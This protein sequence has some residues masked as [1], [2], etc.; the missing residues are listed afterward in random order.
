V[1][2]SNDGSNWGS[3]LATGNPTTQLVTISFPSQTARYIKVVQTG[4]VASNWWSIAELN[5]YNLRLSAPLG[6]SGARGHEKRR[7]AGN[8]GA[9]A[10]QGLNCLAS[11]PFKCGWTPG[12]ERFWPQFAAAWSGHS[13]NDGLM[14]RSPTICLRRVLDLRCSPCSL[15]PCLARC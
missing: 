13:P 15:P 3:A 5:A 12:L 2:V 10:S 9:N 4:T 11:R 8:G 6:V 1:F 14:F 7:Q